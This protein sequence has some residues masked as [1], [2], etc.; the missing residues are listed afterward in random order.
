MS[1]RLW[2][3]PQLDLLVSSLRSLTRV[4]LGEGSLS[5]EVFCTKAEV[6]VRAQK[7]PLLGLV[8]ANF[9][10][11]AIS[12]LPGMRLLRRFA[13]RNDRGFAGFNIQSILPSTVFLHA[14]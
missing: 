14:P 11:E 10:C 4:K 7:I 6:P 3:D 12:R 9:F 13:P 8:I 2:R 5:A 1:S